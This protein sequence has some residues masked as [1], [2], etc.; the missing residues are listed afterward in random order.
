MPPRTAAATQAHM[1]AAAV[2][3][4]EDPAKVAKAVRVVVAAARHNP[5]AYARS[6]VASWPEMPAE[7]RAELRG[8]LAPIVNRTATPDSGEAA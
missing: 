1:R 5:Q 6:V 2:R 8:I 4:A 3:A 7:I